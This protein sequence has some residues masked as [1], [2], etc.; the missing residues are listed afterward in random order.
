MMKQ[1]W[2]WLA[3]LL[4]IAGFVLPL[5]YAQDG[6]WSDVNQAENAWSQVGQAPS[7]GSGNKAGWNGVVESGGGNSAPQSCTTPDAK[8]NPSVSCGS[9]G[10]EIPSCP[11]GTLYYCI[12]VPGSAWCSLAYTTGVGAACGA[13]G[14]GYQGGGVCSALTFWVSGFFC[15]SYNCGCHSP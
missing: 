4:V 15:D 6:G 12:R 1:M 13:A 9:G 2:R 11:T 8:G 3:G 14:G 5:A 7:G 10:L